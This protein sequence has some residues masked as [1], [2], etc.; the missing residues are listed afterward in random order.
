MRSSELIGKL[1]KF[2]RWYYA[3]RYTEAVERR[4]WEQAAEVVK[5]MN[6]AGYGWYHG[7]YS[8]VALWAMSQTDPKAKDAFDVQFGAGARGWR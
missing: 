8:R 4:D 7:V 2:K 3:K 6:D 1:S 5:T